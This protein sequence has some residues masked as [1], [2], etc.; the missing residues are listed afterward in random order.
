MAG[1]PLFFAML[2]GHALADYPLQGDF[3]AKAKNHR[4]PVA[5][6][7]SWIALWAHSLIHGGVVMALTGMWQLGVL[8]TIAHAAI[9][10]AKCE[11][12]TNLEVDQLL[13]VL[14]K[15]AWVGVIA[16]S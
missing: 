6:V 11:G 13:H 4:A 14:C 5:G 8:E 15:A 12:I 2:C 7:P 9:D 3:L 1:F 10:W 16:W